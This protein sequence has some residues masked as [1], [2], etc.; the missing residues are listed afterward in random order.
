MAQHDSTA[1]PLADRI[2]ALLPQTQCTKC[3]FDG[4]RPYAEAIADGRAAINRCAPGGA[5]GIARLATLLATAPLPLDATCGT[6]GPLRVA[7]ID[8]SVCIGCTL[9]I[10]ACPVDAIVG[11]V[12]RLHAV[13]VAQCTG[14]DL[15]VSPCPMDCI[16]MF[17]VDPPRAWTD[18]DAA[19]ARERMN[20]RRV[21]LAREALA[22]DERLAIKAVAKLAEIDGRD[23]ID[24]AAR[25]RKK[26]VVEA[27]IERSRAR[28]RERQAAVDAGSVK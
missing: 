10:Q 22:N 7:R 4:C 1:A 17:D 24:A 15:C 11:A 23:D 8:E 20:A 21:R 28:R 2:D 16:R 26:A 9:C 3:G 25:A 18:A 27:A 12:R 19:A 13:L 14:C 6:E 5:A